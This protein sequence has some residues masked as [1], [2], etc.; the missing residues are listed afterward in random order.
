MSGIPARPLP[1]NAIAIID[2]A[3]GDA[4]KQL[5]VL[6][7]LRFAAHDGDPDRWR[8]MLN[9]LEQN[10]FAPLYSALRHRRLMSLA[11]VV[12][13]AQDGRYDI[14]S[15]DSWKFWRPLR[16]LKHDA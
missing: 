5:A 4:Q 15:G 1:G 16:S 14:T 11:L 8:A 6:P 13:G 9:A 2:A 3:T 7:Q 10:W 12:P